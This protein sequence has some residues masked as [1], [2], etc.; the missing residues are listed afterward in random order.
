MI[1]KRRVYCNPSD[2]R[3]FTYGYRD[4]QS[5]RFLALGRFPHT[6]LSIAR[7]STLW[8]FGEFVLL[9]SNVHCGISNKNK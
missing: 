3:H 7:Q 9:N 5:R 6:V 1:L 2:L 8:G 4:C